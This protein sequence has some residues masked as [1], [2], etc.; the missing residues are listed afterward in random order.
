MIED[1][2]ISIL[3]VYRFCN[4]S[5]YFWLVDFNGF[6]NLENYFIGFV[7][8]LFFDEIISRVGFFVFFLNC[9]FVCVFCVLCVVLCV[10]DMCVIRVCVLNV[11]IVLVCVFVG[12]GG[13]KG[14]GGKN[15]FFR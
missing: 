7:E 12:G 4:G 10:L 13:R 14:V 3:I 9:V 2:G 1:I 5:V 15:L 8:M 11:C 6:L